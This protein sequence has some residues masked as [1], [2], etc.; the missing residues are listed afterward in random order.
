ML[1][2]ESQALMSLVNSDNHGIHTGSTHLQSL[3]NEVY[4][5]TCRTEIRVVEWPEKRHDE[6]TEV[7][8]EGIRKDINNRYAMILRVM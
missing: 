8:I 4:H 2:H 7:G 1:V 3:I 6:E 5:F